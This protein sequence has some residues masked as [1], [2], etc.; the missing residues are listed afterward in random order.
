[1]QTAEEGVKME[2]M[3]GKWP[4]GLCHCQAGMVWPQWGGEVSRCQR[5]EAWSSS[6]TAY[7]SSVLLMTSALRRRL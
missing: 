7:T 4:P 3:L 5:S 1:M 2:H 6:Y